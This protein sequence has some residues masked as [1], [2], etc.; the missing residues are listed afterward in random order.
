MS[1]GMELIKLAQAASLQSRSLLKEVEA[2]VCAPLTRTTNN[3]GRI[4]FGVDATASRAACWRQTRYMQSDMFF[5][6][7]K[8][9]ENL[10]IQLCYY[11]GAT[12]K[13]TEWQND[14]AVL[15]AKMSDVHCASG[16][17]QIEKLFT[18]ALEENKKKKINALIFVGDSCEENKG[19]LIHLARQ[20]GNDGVRLFIFHDEFRDPSDDSSRNS[21]TAQIFSAITDASEGIGAKFNTGAPDVLRDYLKTI[22]VYATGNSKKFLTFIDNGEIKTPEGKRLAARVRGTLGCGPKI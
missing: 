12:F 1:N 17:T 10:S 21:E 22:A 6:A 9:G 11:Y 5:S 20:L 18:H 2:A 4:I 3:E 16:N 13:F 19:N 7:E 15:A 14:A 8:A